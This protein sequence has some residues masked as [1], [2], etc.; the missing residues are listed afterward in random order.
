M[1]TKKNLLIISALFL[2]GIIISGVF[3]FAQNN[4]VVIIRPT[5]ESSMRVVDLPPSL[6][7]A[8]L[9][10]AMATST[11]F[12]IDEFIKNFPITSFDN[13]DSGLLVL[14]EERM[15]TEG[16]LRNYYDNSVFYFSVVNIETETE[17]KIG[18]A[19]TR[20]WMTKAKLLN[21]K[22]YFIS[23]EGRINY[24][25]IPTQS[26]IQL[27]FSENSS[28]ND[29]YISGDLIFYLKNGCSE[30]MSCILGVYDN[31]S[32]QSKVIIEKLEISPVGVVMISDYIPEQ[33]AILLIH[34][35]GDAGVA[36]AS[37]T[38]IDLNTG[39][40]EVL[41]N[42]RYEYCGEYGEACTEMQKDRNDVYNAFKEKY[43][44]KIN[45][46]GNVTIESGNGRD[47]KYLAIN[48]EKG[49]FTLS[50]AWFIGCFER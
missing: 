3:Y 39:E 33:N 49:E 38:K 36:A 14:K 17:Q 10:G 2:S 28:I 43:L 48:T 23:N 42:V 12:K 44:D 30:R 46:C 15:E 1:F 27:E 16:N 47:G 37:L 26:T 5:S 19:S 24:F 32:K 18:V 25:N 22:I 20:P 6:V 41:H 31:E 45:S 34:G 7:D 50:K 8:P 29:F 9:S 4:D 35:M 13:L 21:D 40:E 11:Q